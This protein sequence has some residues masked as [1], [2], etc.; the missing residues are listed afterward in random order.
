MEWLA[1]AGKKH[2]LHNAQQQKRDAAIRA[3]AGAAAA[4]TAAATSAAGT[5]SPAISY[6]PASTASIKPIA[7]MTSTDTKC[8]RRRW[9]K[10]PLRAAH[11]WAT[12]VNT[13]LAGSQWQRW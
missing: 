5:T 10:K 7:T 2:Q 6:M 1:Q 11:Y 12:L 4:T 8:P 13:P 9:R 3:V